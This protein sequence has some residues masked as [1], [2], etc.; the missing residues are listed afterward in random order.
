MWLP[1]LVIG[2]TRFIRC[3]A[4]H[5]A[6]ASQLQ[7]SV[8]NKAVRCQECHGGDDDYALDL[9]EIAAYGPVSSQPAASATARP[10]SFDHGVKFKGKPQ[11]TQVPDLCGTCHANVQKMNPYGLRTDQLA[12]YLVSGHGKQLKEK[13]DDRVAVCIDCHGVHDVLKHDNPVS[14]TF[15][16]NIPSTCGHCHGNAELMKAYDIPSEIVEQYRRSVHGR[17]V[18]EKGDAG[19]PQCATCHGNHAAAPPGFQEV[20]H[21]CGQCHK[22]V[23]EYFLTSIHG[24]LP[25]MAR[26]IGCHAKGGQRFNH[27][28]L[29]ASLSGDT[30][31]ETYSRLA[32]ESKENLPTRFKQEISKLG[33]AT[34][35]GVVCRYC[36]SGTRKDPH[37]QLFAE[38]DK[39]ALGIGDELRGALLDSQWEYAQVA[40]RVSEVGRGVLLVQDEAV[41]A[42]DAKTEVVALY[43]FLHTLD[44]GEIKKRSQKIHDIAKEVSD[45]LDTKEAGLTFRRGSLWPIWVFVAI[46]AVLMYRKYLELRKQYVHSVDEVTSPIACSLVTRRRW[47][48]V[49]LGAMGASAIAGLIWPA[50]AY[51]LPVRKRGGG[52]DR[53]SAG[54]ETEFAVWDA[55]K[56]LVRGKPVVVLRTDKQ[57]QA[58][59]AICTHLGCIVHWNSASRSLD[60]PCH[61]AVFDMNGKVVSGPP[62]KPLPEYSVS[63]AQGEVIIKGLKE[64]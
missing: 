24:R 32:S 27:E 8:H 30:L 33:G 18:L 10:A 19:S 4:C 59:S 54:K 21:V 56:V 35:L 52:S 61:A 51:M 15:F 38:S 34:Q 29:E 2:Q 62:P 9:K 48:D 49:V 12:S 41:R 25:V 22:Q 28:I 40:S 43:A 3:D 36:H 47:F 46:F 58:Y 26:C 5:T 13:G 20:S 57:F 6:Q 31:R 17:N 55:K 16:K 7:L 63:V 53:T 42:E 37:V 60:C 50:I 64:S 45:S 39:I 14:R 44:Q 11:R 1:Q 23:E